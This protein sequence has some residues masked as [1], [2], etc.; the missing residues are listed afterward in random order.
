MG[1]RSAPFTSARDWHKC[2]Y[3]LIFCQTGPHCISSKRDDPVHTLSAFIAENLAGDLSVT[4]LGREAGMAPRTL[5]RILAKRSDKLTPAKL[6]EAV[7]VEAACRALSA[8]D[9]PVKDVAA[10]C[11]FGDD[12]RMRRAFLR[13]LGIAPSD[14]RARF[15]D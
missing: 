8:S 14:Y 2:L 3:A 11:G 6:V 13:K 12:E 4:A 9:R 10:T 5:A 15:S 1:Y 7:R